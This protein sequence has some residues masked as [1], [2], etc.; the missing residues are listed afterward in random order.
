MSSAALN[1]RRPALAW[2]IIESTAQRKFNDHL[3]GI[4]RCFPE[5]RIRKGDLFK[6]YMQIC[7]GLRRSVLMSAF[8]GKADLMRT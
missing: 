2:D 3:F 1:T 7:G 4:K 5:N 8:G 6:I